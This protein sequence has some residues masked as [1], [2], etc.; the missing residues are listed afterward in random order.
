MTIT[1]MFSVLLIASAACF[2]GCNAKVTAPPA[3]SGGDAATT[4]TTSGVHEHSGW[5]CE[6]HGVPEEV[7]ALCNSKVAAEFQKQGDWCNEHNRP[8]SQCFPCH[9][10]HEAR[11]AEQY[12]A[13]YGKKPPKPTG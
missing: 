11:F 7:C 10:E 4:K 8:D 1:K 6:P 5:W 3:K 9:P 2:L 13:K 12:E